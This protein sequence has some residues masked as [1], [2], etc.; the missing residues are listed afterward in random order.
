MRQ[1]IFYPVLHWFSDT[2][3]PLIH[4]VWPAMSLRFSDEEKLVTIKV[5]TVIT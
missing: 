4:E 5:I 2:L 1:L 3:L